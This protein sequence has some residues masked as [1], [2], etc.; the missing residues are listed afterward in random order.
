VG[1][2]GVQLSGAPF[3]HWLTVRVHAPTPQ[4]WVP[5]LT[6]VHAPA[7]VPVQVLPVGS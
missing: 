2:P 7:T 4:V 5:G 3:W 6:L 1:L